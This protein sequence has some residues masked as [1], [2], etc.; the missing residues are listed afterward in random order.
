MLTKDEARR[1]A[2][3]VTRLPEPLGKAA[4]GPRDASAPWSLRTM[5]KVCG[6]DRQSVVARPQD[7][8]ERPKILALDCVEECRIHFVEGGVRLVTVF[9][10][11][12]HLGISD[13]L[14]LGAPGRRL[15]KDCR[16]KKATRKIARRHPSGRPPWLDASS[17]GC[18]RPWQR[19]RCSFTFVQRTRTALAAAAPGEPVLL[20]TQHLGRG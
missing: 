4:G 1:I 11:D 9:E 20:A 2:V 8:A 15:E 14:K 18:S 12:L 5:G 13:L 16:E 19:Q 7:L 10:D 17:S 3:N 6:S